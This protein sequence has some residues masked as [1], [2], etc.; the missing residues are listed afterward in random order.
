MGKSS[1]NYLDFPT[2]FHPCWEWHSPAQPSARTKEWP[3]NDGPEVGGCHG[4]NSPAGLSRVIDSWCGLSGQK[5][6]CA[7]SLYDSESRNA[8]ILEIVGVWKV[9]IFEGSCGSWIQI[10]TP[11]IQSHSTH[12]SSSHQQASHLQAPVVKSWRKCYWTARLSERL[13]EW[14]WQRRGSLSCRT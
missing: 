6:F 12:H 13:L 2:A 7:V 11:A 1:V 3:W 10:F 5:A 14:V 4:H 9:M 8:R